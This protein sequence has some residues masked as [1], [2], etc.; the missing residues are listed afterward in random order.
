MARPLPA[1]RHN[2][3]AGRDDSRYG[4]ADAP[5]GKDQQPLSATVGCERGPGATPPG[6]TPIRTKSTSSTTLFLNSPSVP[7]GLSAGTHRVQRPDEPAS[8]RRVQRPATTA[9]T[10]RVYR[11]RK[12]ADMWPA[13]MWVAAPGFGSLPSSAACLPDVGE[14]ACLAIH[15]STSATARA[16][17]ARISCRS[18]TA[19]A[20]ATA[21]SRSRDSIALTVF[22]KSAIA[23]STRAKTVSTPAGSILGQRHR[24]RVWRGP[25]IL[26]WRPLF[27]S[28]GVT[29]IC[30]GRW[31]RQL[32]MQAAAGRRTSRRPDAVAASRVRPGAAASARRAVGQAGAPTRGGKRGPVEV[33]PQAWPRCSA[34]RP[35]RTSRPPA[36]TGGRAS[37]PGCA[38]RRWAAAMCSTSRPAACPVPGRWS[39]SGARARS[40]RESAR[41]ALSWLRANAARY[42][43]DPAFQRD[44]GV[45]CTCSWTKS[46]RRAS[47]P[48]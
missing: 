24:R 1:K 41:T 4:S 42:G 14:R 32:G 12:P 2:R 10:H 11:P 30:A 37:P 47:R 38:A 3:T 39:L 13:E 19:A 29:A 22:S 16:A 36:V 9:S 34:C 48:A 20:T 45:N 6:R 44:T 40:L 27:A 23:C 46:P 25:V 33:T 5:R 21:L 7:P 35:S 43:L 8:T 18:S 15:R 26:A 31:N 17:A 28:T